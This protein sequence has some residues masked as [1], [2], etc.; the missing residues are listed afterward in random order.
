MLNKH[1]ITHIMHIEMEN[2]IRKKEKTKKHNV[3]INK[4]S[5]ITIKKMCMHARTRTHAHALYR[6]IG[7]KDNV[8]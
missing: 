2:V 3:D 7:V 6:L 4:G 1:S 8:A 5:S